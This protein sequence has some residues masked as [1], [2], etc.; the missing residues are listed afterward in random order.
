MIP[1]IAAISIFF[2][3]NPSADVS[4][5]TLSHTHKRASTAS[6]AIL[7]GFISNAKLT[8][9]FE[10]YRFFLLILYSFLYMSFKNQPSA[11]P[12]YGKLL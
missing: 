5:P 3:L 8:I 1:L 7:V 11:F 2:R 9:F 6:P 4:S 12:V 10:L